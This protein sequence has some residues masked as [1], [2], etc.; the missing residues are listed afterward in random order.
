MPKK[1][2]PYKAAEIYARATERLS[3]EDDLNTFREKY[4]IPK[5][6]R[7]N[8]RQLEKLLY[9]CCISAMNKMPPLAKTASIEGPGPEYLRDRLTFLSKY[10]FP[11]IDFGDAMDALLLGEVPSYI[12]FTS[13]PVQEITMSGN[14]P[15]LQI[16]MDAVA[17]RDELIEYIKRNW[18]S[19]EKML[20]GYGNPRKRIKSRVKR[21]EDDLIA[22]YWDHYVQYPEEKGSTKYIE[23]KVLGDLK[24]A[25]IDRKSDA[26]KS[27]YYRG[28][29]RKG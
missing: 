6:T 11:T 12:P 3:Y 7:G 20:L 23:L 28:R 26:I 27:A 19:F 16:T 22:D 9:Q 8:R 17:T 21:T 5:P 29:K 10:G 13:A 4:S 14:S 24:N 25:G 15:Q 18:K 2:N 1:R